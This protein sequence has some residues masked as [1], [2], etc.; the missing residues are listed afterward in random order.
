MATERNITVRQ[1]AVLSAVAELY[2][3]SGEPVASQAVAQ[4]LAALGEAVSSATVRNVM[5][6][7]SE[8]GLLEQPHTSA[9]RVPTAQGFR[10]YVDRIRPAVLAPA[11]RSRI[12]SSFTGV[13]GTQAFLERTSH[14]LASLSSGVGVALAQV[15]GS[16]VLEHVHFSRLASRSVLA[17]IVMKSGT[18]R[19][20]VL[21][22]E[23]EM[24]M[25][26][27]ETAA[28]FLNEHFRGWSIERVRSEI[29]AR[30]DRERSEYQRLLASVE[31][32]WSRSVP[33]GQTVY[34]EGV[35]NLVTA[36]FAEQEERA[37][38]RDMLQALEEK[39]RVVAL[40]NAY[41]DAHQDSVR[42]VFDLDEHVPEMQ[43]LV[44]I[45]AP[46]MAHGET[47]GA[48]GVIGP[49]RMHYENTMNAVGYVAQLLDR[50][51]QQGPMQR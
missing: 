4:H 45:A 27:L 29:Q 34:V 14:V 37:R 32:L 30:I 11:S 36:P 16:D 38:L 26:E 44:L 31:E 23:R 18:V 12:D 10:I 6:E 24:E 7:L 47:L 39:E 42:V 49:K 43:G 22:L 35:L 46:A 51:L 33:T 13:T 25:L 1:Q 41:V 2:I 50:M 3:A 19:D 9:G 21:T 28:R 17:V 40:L 15:G 8:S 20:R 48:V 5:A